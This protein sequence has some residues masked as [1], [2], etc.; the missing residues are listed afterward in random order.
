MRLQ[1]MRDRGMK[2]ETDFDALDR[3]IMES[4]GK[5]AKRSNEQ[6]AKELGVSTA[7]IRRRLKGL[8]AS[9]VMRVVAVFD[10]A[11]VGFPVTVI[12]GFN[13]LHKNLN[14]AIETLA[15]WPEVKWVATTTGRFDIIVMCRFQSNDAFSEFIHQG[16]PRLEGLRASET[17]VCLDIKKT[18][19]IPLY[20]NYSTWE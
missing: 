1:D 10:P 12:M 6:L 19:H 16:L 9:D 15:E 14:E 2:S 18:R 3:K 8:L 5:D 13:V 20:S 7:T 17:F 4:L 11:R